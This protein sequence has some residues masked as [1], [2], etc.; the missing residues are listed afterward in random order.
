[1]NST[2]VNNIP[3]PPLEIISEIGRK[4]MEKGDLG[5]AMCDDIVMEIAYGD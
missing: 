4:L 1:M 5:T 2:E 3:V